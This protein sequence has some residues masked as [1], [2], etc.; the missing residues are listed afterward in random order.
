[1]LLEASLFGLG[2]F[3]DVDGCRDFAIVHLEKQRFCLLYCVIDDYLHC[4]IV[5]VFHM[6][7]KKALGISVLWKQKYAT[8]LSPVLSHLVVLHKGAEN[9]IIC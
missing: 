1:M 9:G 6:P 8:D 4:A 2:F 3:N 5:D 7:E